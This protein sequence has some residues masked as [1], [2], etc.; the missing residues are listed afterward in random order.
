M[1]SHEYL[2]DR[3]VENVETGKENTKTASLLLKAAR[4]NPEQ[5]PTP[6]P[7]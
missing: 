4:K 1:K 7:P 3:L 6:C 2:N 5:V